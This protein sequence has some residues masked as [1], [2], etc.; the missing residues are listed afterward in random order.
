MITVLFSCPRYGSHGLGDATLSHLL[1]PRIDPAYNPAYE[2]YDYVHDNSFFTNTSTRNRGYFI[3]APDWV[4]ER[5][6]IMSTHYQWPADVCSLDM[7]SGL[8]KTFS[9]LVS[10]AEGIFPTQKLGSSM[11]LW[12]RY[13]SANMPKTSFLNLLST[14]KAISLATVIWAVTQRFLS[15]RVIA[16]PS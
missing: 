1:R 16:W 4:S 6:G 10:Y 3:I 15:L 7:L 2:D 11:V 9:V 13:W 5:K 8:N 12:L 14:D